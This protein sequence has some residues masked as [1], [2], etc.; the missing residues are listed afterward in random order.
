MLRASWLRASLFRASSPAVFLLTLVALVLSA[1][2]VVANAEPLPEKY[3]EL[4]GVLQELSSPGGS[5][6]GSND[7]GCRPTAEHPRPVVL[8]HGTTGGAQITW[9]AFVPMLKN[10][11]YCVFALT[12]GAI[13]GP[14]PISAVGGMRPIEGSAQEIGAFVD[15]VLAATGASTVDIVGHSQ[16]TIATGYYAKVLGGHSK[17]TNDVS[18]APL[19]LGTKALGAEKLPGLFDRFGLPDTAFPICQAC[20]QFAAGAKL[21]DKVN[22][23]GTPY[24]EGIRYTNIGTRYD[25]QVVPFTQG[26]LPGLPGDDVTN[27]VVQDGC[28][29]DDSD[30]TALTDS[31]RAGYLVLNALDPAHPREVPCA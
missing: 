29:K 24:V 21:V 15:R 25:E 4:V 5:L 1:G 6:P 22:A 7:F 3:D 14:W 27:I 17:I 20:G 9:G 23:G 28:E 31:K 30:H 18:L 19:W 2:T 12:Y 13:P 16:G 26:M 11:G 8:V 10:A